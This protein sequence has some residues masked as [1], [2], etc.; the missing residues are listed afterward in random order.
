MS[1]GDKL[2]WAVLALIIVGIYSVR[3]ETIIHNSAYP[4]QDEY[5]HEFQHFA[6]V[7]GRA[8]PPN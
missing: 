1:L 4:N 8:C 5:L 6:G 2:I 3:E 7:K